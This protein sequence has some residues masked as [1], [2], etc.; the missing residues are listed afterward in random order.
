MNNVQLELEKIIEYFRLAIKH[1]YELA[2]FIADIPAGKL[3]AY[4]D[5]KE[6]CEGLMEVIVGNYSTEENLKQTIEDLQYELMEVRE[7]AE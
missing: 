7:D 5:A 1:E 6:K 4:Q 2:D 3:L